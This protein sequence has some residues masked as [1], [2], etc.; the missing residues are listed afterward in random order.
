M[1]DG[2]MC[3]AR[4]FR[5]DSPWTKSEPCKKKATVERD[6]KH[7]CGIHDPVS[8]QEKQEARNAKLRKKMDE[9][10]RISRIKSAAPDLLEALQRV[11]KAG[12]GTSG[13]IILESE[14]EE[15]IRAVIRKATGEKE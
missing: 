15:L 3:C 5:N 12:R 7:Y 9:E 10:M 1:S 11:L 13:R 2:Q 4:V 14:D 8:R 6:G